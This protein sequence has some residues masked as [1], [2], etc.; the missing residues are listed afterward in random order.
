MSFERM[1]KGDSI[2]EGDL[3]EIPI[4]GW[5][6]DLN[7]H[8]NPGIS[9]VE[10]FLDGPSNFGK[11][12]GIAEYGIERVDVG[13][14]L[15]N[16]NYN[17]SGFLLPFDGSSF[18]PGSTHKIYVY[19]YSGS[20]NFHYLASNIIVEGELPE[21]SVVVK[22]ETIFNEDY[23][24]ISGWAIKKE[25][26]SEGVP[27]SL[28]IQYDIKKILFVSNQSGNE[29]IWSINIDGSELTQLTTNMG[30]DVYPAVSPDGK[31][32]AYASQSGN[33]WQLYIMD[34]DGSNKK[35]I[36][37]LPNRSGYPAW[38]FDG[39]YIVFEL[40]IDEDWEI[41]AVE[42]D[43]SNIKRLT[44]NPGSYDWHPYAHP[45]NNTIIYESGPT[46]GE[47]VWT[48]SIDGDNNKC[49]SDN[50]RNYRVPKYSI[51]GKKIVF[52]GYDND[53]REQVFIMDSGGGGIE[54]LTSTP[55]GARLPC[56]SPDNMLIAF[57]TK[58]NAEIFTMNMDGS[59]KKQLT[60][61]PGEDSCP[62]FFYQTAD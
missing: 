35:Q 28:N 10:V 46:G 2:A 27:R 50:Q 17:N 20:G 39:R 24:E 45:F 25:Y 59:E 29:D 14:A 57:N 4:K 54:Q 47:Q 7:S 33:S 5:A 6:V 52:M 11:L 53:G 58:V 44:N 36:T 15:G 12:I 1:Y 26:I 8:D 19:A 62:I 13:N 37:S 38:T 22:A 32:I 41:Y 61:I 43:G 42:S 48:I 60:S 23:L 30:S 9:K 49:I 31:K 40:F 51:D 21:S 56:I 55:D 16:S 18:E 34:W 3:N